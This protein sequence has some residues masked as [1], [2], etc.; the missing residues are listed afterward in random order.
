M[1]KLE[2]YIQKFYSEGFTALKM[3]LA[4][5]TYFTLTKLFS[6]SDQNVKFLSGAHSSQ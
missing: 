1:L 2:V 6:Y 5:H 3:S 4:G